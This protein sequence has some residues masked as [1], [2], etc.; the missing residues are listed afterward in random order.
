LIE[1]LVFK[2]RFFVLYVDPLL[3]PSKLQLI[4]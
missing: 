1:D 3:H 2:P 4:T